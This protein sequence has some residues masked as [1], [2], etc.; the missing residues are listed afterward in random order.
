MITAIILTIIPFSAWGFMDWYE[1]QEDKK[2]DF[3]TKVP[4]PHTKVV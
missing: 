2:R 3:E 4:K 1:A